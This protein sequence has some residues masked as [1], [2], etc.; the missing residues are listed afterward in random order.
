LAE[1]FEGLEVEA[2]LWIARSVKNSKRV[3]VK[4]GQVNKSLVNIVGD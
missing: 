3:A 4:V 1:C 2:R